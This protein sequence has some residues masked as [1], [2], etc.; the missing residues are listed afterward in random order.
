MRHIPLYD[1]LIQERFQRCLDLYLCPRVKKRK[2]NID[3]DSLIPK[4]PDASSMR[5]FPTTLNLSYTG[6]ESGI[7]GLAISPEGTYFASGDEKGVLMIWETQTGKC[8]WTRK[9]EGDVK[10]IDWSSN[11]LIGFCHG[12]KF[13]I[14]TWKY[15]KK[16]KDKAEIIIN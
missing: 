6:H 2:L 16:L 11:N 7:L 5:P 12:E 1:H 9:F 4:L 10:S 13:S 14:M 15:P 3:P 8:L